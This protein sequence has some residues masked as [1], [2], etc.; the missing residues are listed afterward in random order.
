VTVAG[1]T[2]CNNADG[3]VA[4]FENIPLTDI[5][6]SVDSQVDGGTSSTITCGDEDP[7]TT[8]PDGDGSTTLTD[9]EPNV[10]DGIVCT[11][12]IDP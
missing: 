6:V 11:I 3:V 10:P 8:D 9:L 2:T 7:V 12:V 1:N 5:T 4:S